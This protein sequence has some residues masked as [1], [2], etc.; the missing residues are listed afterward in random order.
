MKKLL[1]S[2]TRKV[3]DKF[4]DKNL[5]QALHSA[6]VIYYERFRAVL[7]MKKEKK[8]L[9]FLALVL[10]VAVLF[11]SVP[12]WAGEHPELA[13]SLTEARKALEQELLPL[14]AAGFVGIADSEAEGEVIVFV[15]D[16]QTKQRVPHSF[17]GYTVRTEVT[18]KIQALST[19][20]AEPLTNA[21]ED[22]QGEVR[23][24]VGGTS[25]SAYVTRGADIY[26]YAGTL[27]MV[28]YD[29]KILSNAHVLAINPQTGQFLNTGTPIIQPGSYDGGRLGNRVGALQAYIPIDFAPN[30]KNY[31]DAAIGSIDD[32]V[33]AS[34]GEQFYEGGNYWVE[35]WTEV[36]QGDVVRKSG[37]ITG[38]T[39]GKVIHTNV[40]VVVWYGDHPA[41]FADQIAV[42]QD[43]WSFAAPG[44]SGSAVDKDGEFVGLL[45][46]GSEDYVVI[47]KARHIIDGLGIAVEP[48]EGRYSLAI[49]STP[50]GKVTVPGEGMGIYD[51]GTVVDLVAVPD[52]HYRFVEWTGD[53]RA[54]ADVYAAETTITMNNS[55]SITANFQ[56][57]EG[58]YSLSIS[59]TKGGLVTE[60]G[61]G[62]RIYEAATPV[63]LTAQ[64]DEHYRFVE[65]TGDVSTIGDVNAAATNITMNGSYSITANFELMPG[66]YS[67]TISSTDGGQ[68]KTPGEG[69]FIYNAD[70]VVTLIAQPDEGYEFVKWTG[71]VD[72]IADVYAAQ[73]TITVNGSYSITANFESW[74][75]EPVA[76]LMI[77]STAGGS[78][79]TPGEGPFL[80]PLG[81]KVSLVAEAIGGYQF[82]GWSGDV[83]TIDDV[84]AAST[85][86][87]MDNSYA[88]VAN[89][90]GAGSQCCIA[91][92]AYG[93]PV[94]EE[95]GILREFRDE[96]LLTNVVGRTVA[97]VYYRVS[98]PMAEFVTG[99]PSLKPIVR[100]GLLPAVAMSTVVVGTTLSEKIAIIGLLV[101][102]SVA[103]VVWATRRRGRRPRHT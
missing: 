62:T 93:T 30:A 76:L 2:L 100:A 33:E 47:S 52:E 70:A 59:S 6:G 1:Q 32:S 11:G 78:V 3:G 15:E 39:T 42:A 58:W 89:F 77:S 96:Y 101:L 88:I 20:V 43:N 41:Y 95:I 14:T 94:A 38:V 86:I 10:I 98:P 65:W 55:Y 69:T 45:F 85:I 91:C 48:L 13:K 40:S 82:A 57:E 75:P 71:G 81:A 103:L 67:L 8:L 9:F 21:S 19:Q 4:L 51:D 46:A 80:Y 54:I 37:C 73:T 60:P 50:G 26:R 74:H 35:G 92:T 5:E 68:V 102:V 44:D 22:R 18:G 17:D 63:S 24:L 29:D 23:P 53:V 49:S 72:T 25:L 99:H 12:A 16:E 36:S 56:P 90:Q 7:Q 27:G 31:A 28:T 34:P 61:E 79:T 97:D 83:D 64:A 84:Y 66:W 87:T